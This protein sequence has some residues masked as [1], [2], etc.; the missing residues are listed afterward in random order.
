[1]GTG[2]SSYKASI[3]NFLFNSINSIIIIINGIVMVPIYFHYMSVSTYGAW[4]ATGNVVAM[5]GLLESGFASVITQKMSEAISQSDENRFRVLA[6]A[7]IL[8][9]I[10]M[11]IA[12]FL[13][14]LS[15]SPFI[16]DWV[17]VD[18]DVKRDIQV[19]FLIALCSSSINIL[20]SL[21]GSFPQVWQETKYVGIVHTIT[22]IV[23]IVL[24][25]VF[26]ISG[27]GVCSIALSYFSKAVLNLTF[28]GSWI[29]KTWK[30]K[31][32]G[33]PVYTGKEFLSLTKACIYP[34]LSKL[35]GALM[36]N[37]QSLI[38][39][40]FL[41]PAFAAIY[42]LTSK[43]C[44][45]ACSF[46]SM[47]NG[48]FFALFSLT[49]ATKDKSKIDSVFAN[50]NRFFVISLA[51]VALYSICFSEPICNYWV[52]L[53]KFGGVGL[54]IVVVVAKVVSQLKRYCNN[55]LYTGG[56]INKSA[57]LD[58]LCMLVY[59]GVLVAII[60]SVQE[61]AIP[62]ATLVS[63][64]LFMIWYLRLMRIKLT[65][66]T[67]SLLKNIL[68]ACAIIVPFIVV[69]YIL[70]VDYHNLLKYT[71]YF[72]LFTMLFLLVLYKTNKD[73]MVKIFANFHKQK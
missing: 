18:T 66:D 13:L 2:K 47:A 15:I 63:E 36:G 23:A 60:N 4:L 62:L 51:I 9:A 52:G 59:L 58:I 71:I 37:T 5:L 14:G 17:H 26:L 27:L 29:I 68:K 1:M 6:G 72:I 22:S 7:N 35:S 11:S 24:L 57:K 25:P 65:I 61:Y 28:Q 56:L 3:F 40:H 41:N 55:I 46:V 44:G 34:F 19:A 21:Y 8:T 43:I 48:S 50:V 33:K 30:Q 10:M 64:L 42:D 54:L 16:A 32:I 67:K 70:Q 31:G 38:L 20:V 12:I 45:V 49:L 39:A 53:D 73:F 69:H